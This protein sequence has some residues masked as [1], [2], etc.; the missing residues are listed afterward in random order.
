M[1]AMSSIELIDP[2]ILG[3]NG[4]PLLSIVATQIVPWNHL[5]DRVRGKA[6]LIEIQW[7][8]RVLTID[9]FPFLNDETM[10]SMPVMNRRI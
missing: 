6:A 10:N 5:S 4:H 1:S 3:A 9:L 2:S 8:E 7:L